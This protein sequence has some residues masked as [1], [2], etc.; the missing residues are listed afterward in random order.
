MLVTDFDQ[1]SF[2]VSLV[3]E[4]KRNPLQNASKENIIQSCK[5]SYGCQF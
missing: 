2:S 3:S 1:I 4:I 5:F